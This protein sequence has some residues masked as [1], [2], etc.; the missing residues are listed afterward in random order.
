[1]ARTRTRVVAVVIAAVLGVAGCTA[2]T[3]GRPGLPGVSSESG[4][5]VPRTDHPRLLVTSSDVARL[6]SWASDANP[7]YK[8]GLAA[9]AARAKADM[10]A[11]HA[12]GEDTG[13]KDYERYP[14]EWYAELFAF[15]SVVAPDEAARTD[16]GGRA[17]TLLM[18]VIDRA[19]PG[20]G[21]EG[22]AFRDPQFA[23]FNR[24]RW[25]GDGF[26]LTV[27]WAYAYFSAEDKAKIRTV[28]L[29]WAGELF[30]AYPAMVGGGGAADFHPEGPFNDP[31]LLTDKA[32]VRW[33]MNNYFTAHM[34]NLG[35]LAM[36]LD[37]A[38]DP[39]GKL[40]GYLRNATGQWLFM[41]DAA[42]HGDAAGG[43]SPEGS[44]YSVSSLA[45]IAQ[46]LLALHTAGQDDPAK[47]GP[48]VV[49]DQPFW[50]D[51]RSAVLHDIPPRSITTTSQDGERHTVFQ[52]A[53]YGD[54][55]SY[56]AA[57][58]VDTL[59]PVALLAEGRGDRATVDVARWYSR[60][61]PEDGEKQLL[62]RAG[63]AT[64]Q[65]L[66]T[67]LYFLLFDPAAPAP[68][69]PR[70]NLPL[71]HV[72]TGL[73][74]T[75]SVSC[76]C[77]QARLFGFSLTWKAIDHQGGD[78]NDIALWRH[79]EW[80]TKQRS[81]YDLI[82]LSDYHNTLAVENNP[83]AG[84]DERFKPILDRGSQNPLSAANDPMITGASEGDGY[85]Y[86]AGDATNLYNDAGQDRTDVVD[87][88][89]AVVWLKPDHVVVLDRAETKTDGRF[90]QFWLQL[91][92]VATVEG[93]RAT[94]RTAGG[95]QLATTTLLP[96]GATAT[97]Q[98]YGDDIGRQADGDPM[99]HRLRVDAP[100]NPRSTRFLHVLQGADGNATP[101][102]PALVE[103]VDGTR[104]VGAAVADT[105]VL[106]PDKSQPNIPGTT[107][108]VPNGVKRMLVTGL[109]PDTGY[110][111]G[112]D[113]DRITISADGPT[114]TDHGGVLVTTV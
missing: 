106:F 50:T 99:T 18:H 70:P 95:Q 103:S 91:P 33:A 69:D 52:P 76:W 88:S 65:I 63:G 79:G 97:V 47:W 7:I 66:S 75:L 94:T 30:T 101:D 59:T 62:E 78:G 10:D 56:P 114:M 92:A 19:L 9:Y 49:A 15:M 36:A 73:N 37:E 81:G 24:S 26:G 77:D 86:R 64:D 102:T 38:D 58:L 61:D 83:A 40:R 32:Q 29:R 96:A 60:Y 74:R 44:E 68:P 82:W 112:R 28:F 3:S 5:A 100:G 104:F 16:Y 111:A 43:L 21:S 39:D 72:A 27:D 2:E 42:Q 109:T 8:D 84:A 14:S 110:T 67:I 31:A 80:L 41:T 90:K 22:E 11:G 107:I 46:F 48:Q 51:F 23:T 108:P 89:R 4:R 25:Y 54:L 55:Q 53:D 6:R 12:P 98:Q 1:M 85:L 105:M 20:A 13:S 113:G 35:Y 34:R 17:R 57:D 71:T 93:N 87:V 45:Y